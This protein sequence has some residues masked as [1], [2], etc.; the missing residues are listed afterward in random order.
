MASLPGK[1]WF[2]HGESSAGCWG[3]GPGWD[4][5]GPF[6]SMAHGD[7]LEIPVEFQESEYPYQV[8]Y[9]R[10]REDS[11]GA[12]Q[13][14][15]GLGIEKC[16]RVTAACRLNTKFDRTICPPWGLNGG[17]SGATGR[18]EVYREGIAP[19]IA[20]RDDLPFYPGDLVKV[21]TGGGG[22]YGKPELRAPDSVKADVKDGYVSTSS[23]EADYG[24]K[25]SRDAMSR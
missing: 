17:K 3:A 6:R 21:F 12:G 10:L 13:F 5:P 15:G 4:G 11:G 14:R 16:Y 24:V 8:E 22:G 2:R 18:V 20:I 9:I 23:A 19:L 7:T 1:G 25:L